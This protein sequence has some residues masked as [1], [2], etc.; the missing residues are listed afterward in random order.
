MPLATL[1]GCAPSRLARDAALL[2]YCGARFDLNST[3]AVGRCC[4]DVARL[5]A[6]WVW[7]DRYDSAWLNV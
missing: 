6:Q 2:F 4:K 7:R 5:I 1:I 3:P